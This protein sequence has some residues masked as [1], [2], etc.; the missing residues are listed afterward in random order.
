MVS[1]HQIFKN[2]RLF[3]NLGFEW[4][5]LKSKGQ[6]VE[7]VVIINSSIQRSIRILSK[8]SLFLT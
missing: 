6:E 4:H 1:Y 5:A 3:Q 2:P 7:L 8:H